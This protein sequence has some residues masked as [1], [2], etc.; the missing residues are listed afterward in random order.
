MGFKGKSAQIFKIPIIDFNS[1]IG[2]LPLEME[3]QIQ[4]RY[5]VYILH[6]LNWDD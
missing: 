2:S 1:V 3:Y 5:S 4:D 6:F